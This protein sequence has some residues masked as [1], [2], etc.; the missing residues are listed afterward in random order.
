MNKIAQDPS[1]LVTVALSLVAEAAVAIRESEEQSALALLRE[2]DIANE[3]KEEL[4]RA[5]LRAER[6]EE[7]LRLAEAQIEQMLAAA[8]QADKEL[9][10]LRSQLAAEVAG[11]QTIIEAIR[12]QLP[13]KAGR[14][15]R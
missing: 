12:T 7:M 9:E 3:I 4:V 8:E 2:R 10:D 15:N 14:P 1:D 6:T 13:T 11:I 5:E